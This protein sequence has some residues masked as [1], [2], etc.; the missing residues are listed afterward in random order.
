[1]KTGLSSP[2]YPGLY[3]IFLFI[4]LKEHGFWRITIGDALKALTESA[5]MSV[6]FDCMFNEVSK[7]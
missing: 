3:W 2:S 4:C 6:E 5:N 7:T 1:M